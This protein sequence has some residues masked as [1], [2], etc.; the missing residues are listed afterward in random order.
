MDI[1]GI[2]SKVLVVIVGV[3]FRPEDD[4]HLLSTVYDPHFF[5]LIWHLKGQFS[6]ITQ[7]HLR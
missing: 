4:V 2:A 5:N 7:K 3:G 1:G 6:Q